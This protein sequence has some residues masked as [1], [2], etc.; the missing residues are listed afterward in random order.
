MSD[1]QQPQV[2]EKAHLDRR[3]RLKYASCADEPSQPESL[4]SQR[5]LDDAYDLLHRGE[6]LPLPLYQRVRIEYLN[7]RYYDA[8]NMFVAATEHYRRGAELA[9]QIPDLAL[10]AQLKYRESRSSARPDRDNQFRRMFETALDAWQTWRNLPFRNITDD[11]AFEFKLADNASV[12]AEMV[13]EYDTA[14]GLLERAGVLLHNLRSRPDFTAEQYANFDLLLTWDWVTIYIAMGDYRN[15][16]RRALQTRR[17]GKDLLKP[18]N[19]V[20]LQRLIAVI[21]LGC[22]EQGPVEGYTRNRLLAVAGKA[23][24]EAY[25]ALRD[26]DDERGYAMTLLA[27]AKLLGLLKMEEGR[28]EKIREAEK[29]AGELDDPLL[30]GQVEIAWGDEFVIQGDKRQARKFYR[31]VE[32][33]MTQIEFLELAVVARQRLAR[34]AKLTNRKGDGKAALRRR[35]RKPNDPPSDD[36]IPL[37]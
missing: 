35:A 4:L 7:G 18:I 8:Q 17:K 33:D 20:R 25:T 11:I 6:S 14:V 32:Q 27:E 9:R 26:C 15:A 30:Q 19:R 13:A 16:F 10:Y 21:A 5:L 1:D 23:I 3:D 24:D 2:S 34:L 12:F 37:N 28:L 22:A 36:I 31:K 29:I